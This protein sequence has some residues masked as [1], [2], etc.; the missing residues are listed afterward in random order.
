ME[1]KHVEAYRKFKDMVDRKFSFQLYHNNEAGEP[2]FSSMADVER[3][4][5]DNLEGCGFI[6][7]ILTEESI[8]SFSEEDWSA[9]T[10]EDYVT[11][12]SKLDDET[13]YIIEFC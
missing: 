6:I 3:I 8:F 4:N 12:G 5:L 13:H 1:N 9:H 11:F 2:H 10:G 7:S